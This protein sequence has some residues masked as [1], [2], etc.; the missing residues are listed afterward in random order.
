MR[1][2]ARLV[3]G[4][5]AG[6][7]ARAALRALAA[8][9]TPLLLLAASAA[10]A[11]D[12]LELSCPPQISYRVYR[13]LD[14]DGMEDLIA[15]GEREAWLWHGRARPGKE[16]DAK[17]VMPQGAALFD[18]GPDDAKEQAFVVRTA[19]GYFALRPGAEPEALPHPSGPGLP[20][21]PAN[22]LWRAFFGDFDGD[23]KTDFLDVSL[24]GYTIAFAKGGAVRI[25]P[26]LLETAAT[27]A[28]AASGKL[29]ARYALG[30]WEYG[31]FDGDGFGDFAVL[32]SDGLRIYPGLAAGGFDPAH[33]SEVT[34][35]DAA[36]A[37]LWFRDFNGDGMTDVLAI[38][39]HDGVAS[40]LL[41]GEGKGLT[42]ATRLGFTVPGELR[43]PV[44]ADLDGDGR[45]DLALPYTARPSIEAAVR[46]I[47][48]GEAIVK[49]P[50]FLNRGGRACFAPRADAQFAFPARLRIAADSAGRIRIGGLIVV[51]HGADV[52]G[53]G[54]TDLVASIGPAELGIFRGVPEGLFEKEPWRRVPIPDCSDYEAV[55]TAAARLNGDAASDIILHYAG[56]GRRPDRLFLLLSG[57]E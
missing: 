42:A 19:Q 37:D 15:V 48:R 41:A 11:P 54:R 47:A 36:E 12:L 49:V 28:V 2:L 16:P 27:R 35:P 46:A 4:A 32:E 22:L 34:L 1:R 30:D 10:A 6:L 40:L 26:L 44:V 33:A 24:A 43:S 17:L 7:R 25:P 50:V 38:R 29:V 14:H 18:V 53:D 52:D 20:L 9:G 13:D 3:R 23:G 5:L 51:E 45:L 55:Y 31:D 21:A 39:G 57:K 8:P 56:A